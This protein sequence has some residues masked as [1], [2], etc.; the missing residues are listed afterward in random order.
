MRFTQAEVIGGSENVQELYRKERTALDRAGVDVDKVLKVLEALHERTVEA[1]ARQQAT[2]REKI[3]NT[4]KS[5]GLLRELYEYWS[6]ALDA[7]NIRRLRSRM[8]RPN[9]NGGSDELVDADGPEPAVTEPGTD[10]T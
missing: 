3:E 7:A 4:A 8:R 10:A 5:D 2:T 1:K 9:G 6:G